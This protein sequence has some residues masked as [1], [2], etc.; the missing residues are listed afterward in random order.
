MKI[1]QTH[2][3]NTPWCNNSVLP[4]PPLLLAKLVND[5]LTSLVQLNLS[6]EM[7]HLQCPFHEGPQASF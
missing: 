2:I 7:Q 6:I 5:P 4:P 3:Q 1:H